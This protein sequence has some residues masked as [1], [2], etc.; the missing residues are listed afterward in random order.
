MET[1]ILLTLLLIAIGICYYFFSTNSITNDKQNL[2]NFNNNNKENQQEK[3]NNDSISNK[4]EKKESENINNEKQNEKIN[5]ESSIN[6]IEK[7]PKNNNEEKKEKNETNEN[8]NKQK[9]ELTI[10]EQI[11]KIE[12]EEKEKKILLQRKEENK[13]KIINHLKQTKKLQTIKEMKKEESIKPGE[14]PEIDIE[15]NEEEEEQ[16]KNQPSK[17]KSL[18]NKFET[19]SSEHSDISITNDHPPLNNDFLQNSSTMDSVPVIKKNLTGNFEKLVTDDDKPKIK[20]VKTNKD[21]LLKAKRK[22]LLMNQ[23]ND[24]V[25]VSQEITE[26]AKEL[27]KKMGEHLVKD[28]INMNFEE[29]NNNIENKE[30]QNENVEEILQQKLKSGNTKKKKRYENFKDD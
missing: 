7:E 3:I 20:T 6:K 9:P 16:Q 17:F 8:I 2:N 11:K 19:K 10:E 4:N 18:L 26:K 1:S 21:R 29:N 23:A 27:E 30:I 25:D 22:I 14:Q 5:N 12:E 15:V 24:R 28:K 13:R